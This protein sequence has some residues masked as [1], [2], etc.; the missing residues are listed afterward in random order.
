LVSKKPFPS[1]NQLRW[2]Q[3]LLGKRYSVAGLSF[4]LVQLVGVLSVTLLVAT[5]VAADIPIGLDN[6][7]SGSSRLASTPEI[8]AA[9]WIR[10]HTAPDVKIASR[11]V[12]LVYHYSRRRVI[13]FPPITNPKVLMQGIREHHIQYLIIIDRG[14]NYY[15]PPEMV[16]FDKL[17][18]TYPDEFRLVEEKGKLRIYEVL[19]E[20]ADLS[21]GQ[22]RNELNQTRCDRMALLHGAVARCE[23]RCAPIELLTSFV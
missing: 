11:H 23:I 6:L 17:Y 8:Q 2:G 1:L 10:S 14:F 9:D 3:S 12:G 15:L 21:A 7:I 13:W 18:T 5:T 4:S 20:S 22:R 19:R 16:C